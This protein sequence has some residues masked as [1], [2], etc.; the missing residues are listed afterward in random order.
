MKGEPCFLCGQIAADP[1]LNL[2]DRLLNNAWSRRPVLL[3][4]DAAVAMPSIGALAP[5]HV[6]ICPK[7]H[8]R[9]FAATSPDDEEGLTALVATTRRVLDQRLGVPVH[10]FEH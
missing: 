1:E 8:C 4:N 2:L 6:L 9:S 5:G 7:R 3:E 10:T